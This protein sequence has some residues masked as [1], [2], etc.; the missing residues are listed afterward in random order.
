MVRGLGGS[1]P[2]QKGGGG[3]GRSKLDYCKFVSPHFQLY[4]YI[5]TY[6]IYCKYNCKN[7]C[8]FI[9]EYFTLWYKED[10]QH[11]FRYNFQ[12]ELL[13]GS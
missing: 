4:I 8:K 2:I 12:D 6:N 1:A 9:L 5:H 3:G 10:I 7:T 11:G 13:S